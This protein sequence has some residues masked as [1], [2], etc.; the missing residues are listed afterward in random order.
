VPK[1]RLDILAVERG[2]VE[3]RDE[4][5]RLIMA[6]KVRVAGRIADKPGTKYSDSTKIEVVGPKSPYASRGGEKLAA[7]L[8]AFPVDVTGNVCLDLGA[9]TGGFTSCLLAN[10]AAFVYAVD[11]GKGLL[12]WELRNDERVGIMEGVNARHL[13]AASL[14]PTPTLLVADLSFISLDKVLPPVIGQLTGL[15]DIICL[16]KPQFEA[17]RD[18]VGKGGVVS[19]AETH[20]E[21]LLKIAAMYDKNGYPAAGLVRSPLLG[22]AGNV[23]FL[24]WGRPRAGMDVEAMICKVIG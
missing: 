13:N 1:T 7:A 4:A 15:T 9:S 8:E 23:E 19:D 18:R 12:A 11:V 14:G 24:M 16:V 21:V 20:R 17:E 3:N 10:G 2:F 22:P 5:Q 6:G